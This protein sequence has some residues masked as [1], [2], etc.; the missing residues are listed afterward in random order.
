MLWRIFLASVHHL[1]FIWKIRTTLIYV[2]HGTVTTRRQIDTWVVVSLFSFFI[3]EVWWIRLP[4]AMCGIVLRCLVYCCF[5]SL[6]KILSQLFKSLLSA[7][8]CITILPFLIENCLWLWCFWLIVTHIFQF[9]LLLLYLPVS[10][11]VC[12]LLQ[13]CVHFKIHFFSNVETRSWISKRILL[14][15]SLFARQTVTMI[16]RVLIIKL[17]NYWQSGH[18]WNIGR[19]LLYLVL[20]R[21]SLNLVLLSNW[22]IMY[23]QN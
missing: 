8:L 18:W 5:E 13:I 4:V 20:W 22:T 19:W 7:I 12:S 9:N 2:W 10:N 16:L 21:R 15:M 11:S 17:T 14:S 3:F 23:M 6:A 1:V